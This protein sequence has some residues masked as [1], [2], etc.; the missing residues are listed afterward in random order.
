[1][2]RRMWGVRGGA[3]AKGPKQVR[4]GQT[5]NR[6]IEQAMS[7]LARIPDFMTGNVQLPAANFSGFVDSVRLA[8]GTQR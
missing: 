1:M 5:Q 2:R 6:L 4:F 3:W 7:A 8:D